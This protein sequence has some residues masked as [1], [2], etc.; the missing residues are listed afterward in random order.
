M[1]Y[2]KFKTRRPTF[3][4]D[5]TGTIRYILRRRGVTFTDSRVDTSKLQQLVLAVVTKR[6]LHYTYT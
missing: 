2:F 6:D 1:K 4:V 3:P 5:V